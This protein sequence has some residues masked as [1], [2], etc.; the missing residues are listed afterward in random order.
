MGPGFQ[1]FHSQLCQALEKPKLS[2]LRS[3]SSAQG[4]L[5]TWPHGTWSKWPHGTR[6]FKLSVLNSVRLWKNLSIAS[7][8]QIVLRKEAS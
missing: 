2:K 5:L 8:A 4:C 7:Y 1:A 6:F 3:D